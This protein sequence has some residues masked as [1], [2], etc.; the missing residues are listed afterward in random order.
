MHETKLQKIWCAN[1]HN[2]QTRDKSKQTRTLEDQR[3]NLVSIANMILIIGLNKLLILTKIKTTYC[4][5][6]SE[7][8]E[9]YKTKKFMKTQI[10]H[11]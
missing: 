10:K 1:D 8:D 2:Q 7:I 5:T 4:I 6:P 3:M 9:I 11:K